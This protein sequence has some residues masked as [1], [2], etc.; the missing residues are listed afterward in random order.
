MV[1]RFYAVF[2]FLFH[3]L[4]RFV[5][6]NTNKYL[7]I[8]FFPKMCK[9]GALEYCFIFL[10]AEGTQMEKQGKGSGLGALSFVCI[11]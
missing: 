5:F 8:V 6:F 4:V 9:I 1:L 2:F 11:F 7:Y 10:E 3:M